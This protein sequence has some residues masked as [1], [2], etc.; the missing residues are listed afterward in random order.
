MLARKLAAGREKCRL[1]FLLRRETYTGW[2]WTDISSCSQCL[3][4]H[5]R[6]WVPTLAVRVTW[7]ARKHHGSQNHGA[8]VLPRNSWLI[9]PGAAKASVCPLR[10]PGM[11]LLGTMA[12]PSLRCEQKLGHGSS[13]FLLWMD[14]LLPESKHFAALCWAGCHCW[15]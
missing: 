1:V 10:G 2:R 5:C 13:S 14:P 15:N 9:G 3:G 4:S 7:E 6:A 12:A 8:L 11:L